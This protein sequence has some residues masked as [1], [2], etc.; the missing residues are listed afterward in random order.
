MKDLSKKLNGILLSN[1]LKE[2]SKLLMKIS[3]KVTHLCEQNY[4][5][6]MVVVN[7]KRGEES[8]GREG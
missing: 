6:Q 3:R 7:W 2:T 1:S 8:E 5:T 4:L